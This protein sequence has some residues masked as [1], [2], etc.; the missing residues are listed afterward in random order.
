MARR[1]SDLVRHSIAA[2]TLVCAIDG[3]GPADAQSV[4]STGQ[5]TPGPVQTPTWSVG[6]DLIVGNTA[7]G[8]L[9]I[10]AGAT[11]D[12]S[13]AYIGNQTGG[14]GTVTV[15]GSDGSG[16][17]STWTNAGMMRIGVESGSNGALN[18]LGGGVVKGDSAIIGDESGSV[19]VV[20][21]SGTG[22]TLTLSTATAFQIGREGRG[23]LLIND[24][25][26]VHSGQASLGL[27]GGEGHVTVAGARTVWD[28]VGN[29]YV[30]LGGTG[31]LR[32]QDGAAVSTVGPAG[33]T[34]AA[35]IY[36]GLSGGS[37]GTVTVS[38]ATADT[39]TLSAS[40][41]IDVGQSGDGTL[42]IE[43]G[44]WVRTSFDTWMARMP[45]ATGTL[46]LNGDAS[47]R[48]VLETGAVVKGLGNV[49]LNLNGGIL[50]ANRDESDFLSGF[51]TQ[52]VG[53]GGAWFDTNTHEVGVGTAFSGSSSL[54]KLGAGTLTL[55]GNSTA[56]T[57]NTEVRA[58]TL[59]VDGVLGGSM[60]VLAGA[61]LTGTGQVGATGNRGTIAPGPRSGFGTL[62]IAGDYG[63]QGGNLEIR[64]KLGDDNSPTDRL[65]ITGG[66][67]GTTPVTVTNV[68]GEGALTQRGIQVVQVNGLS[69]GQFNLANG[70]YVI[71]GQPALVAGAY[72]YVLQKDPANGNWYLRSSLTQ[73]GAPEAGV[74]GV[75]AP[76]GGNG[77]SG[78]PGPSMYQPGVP[79]YEAY[80]N[81]LLSLSQLPTLRQRVGNRLYDAADTGR[82]GVWGRVESTTSRAN[83]SVSSTGQHQNTDSW[84]A[85]FG[86]DRILSGEQGGSRLVGGFN[87]H[88]GTAKTHVSSRYGDGSI[89][90]TAYG[91]GPTLTW[92][93]NDGTYV[94]TQAQATW[95]NSDLNSRLAGKL[96]DGQN[97]RSYGLS[98]EAGKPFALKE[99]LA[100]IPQA[101]VSYVSSHFGRFNDKFDARVESDKGDSLQGRLGIA[102]DYQRNW[103]DASGKARQANVYGVLNVKREFLDGTRV[104]VSSV[105]VSSRMGRTWG[106]MGVGANFGWNERYALYGEV[107]ADADF[108][109]SYV[110]TA[111]A[112]L[113][114]A[115]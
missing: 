80:A 44:G 42:N 115:F 99:G 25:A 86:V 46:N 67:F 65:V 11:V 50:R 63:A 95:F 87:V 62:T 5:I 34:S 59:Q 111:T 79:V 90:T 43:K 37:V 102:L 110:V 18:V 40:D 15:S 94:D 39:S 19:G 103:H 82:N 89:D 8:A 6:A 29:I 72:G 106:G 13:D 23:T 88:Y 48:G 38:S 78:A 98:V 45:T 22:S 57:G 100:L 33:P 47:G 28:P 4:T 81:T 1:N 105:P 16:Q 107:G 66:T 26:V 70:D 14:A 52:A 60:N 49:T 32:V 27:G 12:N 104:Q 84:K 61:R 41:G 83:P 92:Y 108:S 113:R 93:G 97:A 109:G 51:A 68:G 2:V 10:D 101:Q 58:G 56:F 74:P 30:G 77:P 76:E 71:A 96:R 85:Q 24:G 75:G 17:A 53:A 21:V 91:L 3:I 20:T 112:G 54:T 55:T 35:S 114:I 64:T 73:V 69:A 36:I 7:A 9:T 31:E